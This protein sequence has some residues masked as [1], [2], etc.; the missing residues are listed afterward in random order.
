MSDMWQRVI[1]N[2]TEYKII[3]NAIALYVLK[4]LMNK[5]EIIYDST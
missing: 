3:C 4:K 1:V 5:L 2:N